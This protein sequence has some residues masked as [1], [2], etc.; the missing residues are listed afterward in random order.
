MTIQAQNTQNICRGASI[1]SIKSALRMQKS[2]IVDELMSHY[3]AKS[4]D[5]LALMLSKG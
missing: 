5:D 3:G 2:N 4:V 1:S